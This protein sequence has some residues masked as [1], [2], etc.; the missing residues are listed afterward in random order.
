VHLRADTCEHIKITAINTL[1]YYDI[2]CVPISAFEMAN[3][4]G[5]SVFPYSAFGEKAELLMKL[6]EDG[7]ICG[8]SVY[9]NDKCKI[10][11][12]IN[13]TI[14]HEVG[15]YILGHTSNGEEEEKEAS[16]FAKYTLAPPPLIHK[17]LE[18]P[19]IEDIAE[20]FDISYTA[21]RNALNYYKKWYY[22]GEIDFTPYE[23]KLLRLFNVA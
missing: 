16:F 3:K 19:T 10:Y 5:L 13:H 12:R 7:F 22:Y 21:A 6:S 9:Y 14:M 17:M 4:I 23:E 1:E 20:I 15:H 8:T 2:K 11:G 18:N